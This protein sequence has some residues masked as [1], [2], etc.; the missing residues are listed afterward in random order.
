MVG[1]SYSSGVLVLVGGSEHFALRSVRTIYLYNVTIYKDLFHKS[2]S[3]T[4]K[5][6]LSN[7]GFLSIF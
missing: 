2:I 6:T 5:F 3:D 4:L 1:K 7:F